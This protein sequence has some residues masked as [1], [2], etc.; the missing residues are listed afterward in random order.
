MVSFMK[1]HAIGA[2]VGLVIGAA[3]ALLFLK[4]ATVTTTTTVDISEKTRKGFEDE[5]KALRKT[6]SAKAK[7][8]GA[9]G[10]KTTILPDGTMIVEGPSTV[11][12]TLSST[13]D[14][15]STRH[16]ESSEAERTEHREIKVVRETIRHGLMFNA[17]HPVALTFDPMIGL[18]YTHYRLPLALRGGAQ[19]RPGTWDAYRV[20]IAVGHAW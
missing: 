16:A 20:E 11:D 18:D 19:V 1:P 3:V 2:G 10:S 9:P 5:I 14:E 6:A 8:V 15:S 13:A 17:S 4:P 7:V 12:F